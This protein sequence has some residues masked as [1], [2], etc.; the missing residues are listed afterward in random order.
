[1][2][3][4][5]IKE[6]SK[7]KVIKMIRLSKHTWCRKLKSSGTTLQAIDEKHIASLEEGV[8]YCNELNKKKCKDCK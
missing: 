2:K 1:M 8:N 7:I 5:Y 6:I 4:E 3:L